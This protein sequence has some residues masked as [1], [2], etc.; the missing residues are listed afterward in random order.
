MSSP[1]SF[2]RRNQKKL[3]VVFGVLIMLTFVVGD[4]ISRYQTQSGAAA[5]EGAVVTWKHGKLYDRDG[6]TLRIHV[7]GRKWDLAPRGYEAIW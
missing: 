4:Y 1:L 5:P 6:E 7:Y 3:L 2:F